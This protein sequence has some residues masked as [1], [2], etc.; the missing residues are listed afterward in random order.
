[1]VGDVVGAL[2]SGGSCLLSGV[3]DGV[4]AVLSGAVLSG[5]V[6]LDEGLVELVDGFFDEVDD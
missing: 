1:M 6:L 4:G 2:L 3:V 5:F